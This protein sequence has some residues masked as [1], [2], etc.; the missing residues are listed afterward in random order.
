MKRL[1]T[2]WLLEWALRPFPQTDIA[3][4]ILRWRAVA[5]FPDVVDGLDYLRSVID[6][7]DGVVLPYGKKPIGK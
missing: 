2:V 3:T 5:D 7:V 6:C 1:Y 4:T